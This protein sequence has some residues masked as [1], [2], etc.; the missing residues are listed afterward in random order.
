MR[1]IHAAVAGL[2]LLAQPA[3]AGL[4]PSAVLY[5]PPAAATA[6]NGIGGLN[7]LTDLDATQAASTDGVSQ[8]W[9]NLIAAPA[10]GSAASAYACTRGN[11]GSAAADDPAY[12]GTAGTSGGYWGFSGAQ[13][14][15]LAGANTAY[16]ANL[17][18]DGES[19]WIAMTVNLGA[20]GAQTL[21]STQSNSSTPGVTL[22]M[23][24]SSTPRFNMTQYGTAAKQV[25]AYSPTVNTGTDYVVIVSHA[26][27]GNTRLW[28]NTTAAFESTV[29]FIAASV[30]GNHALTVGSRG[31]GGFLGAGAKLRSFAI[32]QDYLTDAGAAAIIHRLEARHG[33]DYDGNG[34]VGG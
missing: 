13:N 15:T 2:C 28:V 26:A 31:G 29:T 8:T 25:L 6:L 24:P 27:G 14:F 30:A 12:N 32:G 4:M 7:V 17:Q 10:D 34:T 19:F 5:H 33:I 9:G 20:T 1:T 21:W 3:R 11:T 16:L 18:N 23:S 22:T